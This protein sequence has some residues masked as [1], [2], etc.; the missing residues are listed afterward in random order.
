MRAARHVAIEAV[1]K[2][3]AG[4]GGIVGLE[5]VV[6]GRLMGERR[7]GRVAIP[8]GCGALVLVQVQVRVNGWYASCWVPKLIVGVGMGV[9]LSVGVGV[10]VVV[11]LLML[12]LVL[13][14]M[15]VLV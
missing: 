3:G 2:V 4:E 11:L 6:C 10:G 5:E 8:A 7:H 12:M 14:V 1:G 9:G 13:V 15:L